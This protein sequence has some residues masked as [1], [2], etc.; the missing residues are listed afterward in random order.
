MEPPFITQIEATSS[1]VSVL[2]IWTT[3]D[4]SSCEDPVNVI[5]SLIRRE[6]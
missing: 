4:A 1:G 6:L 3:L 2:V 5:L